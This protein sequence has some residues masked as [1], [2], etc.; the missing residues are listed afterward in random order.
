MQKLKALTV[1]PNSGVYSFWTFTDRQAS[2]L[3]NKINSKYK[4][5]YTQ[6]AGLSRARNE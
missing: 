2:L 4:T 6:L 1:V 3:S 5:E